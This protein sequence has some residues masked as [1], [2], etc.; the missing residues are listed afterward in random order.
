MKFIIKEVNH[1]CG[2]AIHENGLLENNDRILI[3]FSGGYDSMLML[4]LIKKWLQKAP[5]NFQLTAVYLDMGFDKDYFD[6]ICEFLKKSEISYIAEM[7][8]FG[9]YAH[10]DKNRGKS[11]C[12]LCSLLRRKRLF[13]IT[14][15]LD[16]NKIAL[17]HNQ[18]DLIETFFMNMTYRGELST[19]LPRQEMFKGLLNIIRPLAFIP[20]YKVIEACDALKLPRF[21]NP[22]PSDGKTRRE[23]IKQALEGLYNS[24]KNARGNIFRALSNVKREYLL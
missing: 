20:K 9:V 21:K 2:K 19:M 3:A 15:A 14:S 6:K 10:S 5:I 8:D 13:E 4:Y 24:N 18:D 1:L 16:C 11:P 17:G 7:T 22:C 23:E 12:F